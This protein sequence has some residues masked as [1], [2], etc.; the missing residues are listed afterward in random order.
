M[1]CFKIPSLPVAAETFPLFFKV[2]GP[3]PCF[4]IFTEDKMFRV[5]KSFLFLHIGS[6][7]PFASPAFQSDLSLYTWPKSLSFFPYGT[8][9]T[10]S[11]EG[12][13]AASRRRNESTTIAHFDMYL[14]CSVSS[15]L[16]ML[17]TGPK[18]SK[19]THCSDFK[20]CAD[21]HTVFTFEQ[22]FDRE[23]S[24]P[25]TSQNNQ[26]LSQHKW[27]KNLRTAVTTKGKDVLPILCLS[28]QTQASLCY[29]A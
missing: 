20:E 29:I 1:F 12:I 17:E 22:C 26:E 16:Q 21:R 10:H 18:W 5:L 4:N 7:F 28:S 14:I 15:I 23:R 27:Q 2:T 19:E 11:K 6:V 3:R 9:R 24:S 8:Q 25:E 13:H